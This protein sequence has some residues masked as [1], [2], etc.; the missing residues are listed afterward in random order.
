MSNRVK[1]FIAGV[2]VGLAM[3]VVYN[4]VR[5]VQAMVAH[6]HQEIVKIET[7][8]SQITGGGN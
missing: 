4:V 2:L 8:L 6:D 1:H 7:F 3:S 5:D